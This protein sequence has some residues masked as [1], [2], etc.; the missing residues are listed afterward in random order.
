MSYGD[1]GL[2][3]TSIGGM[4]NAVS[5]VLGGYNT[6]SYYRA[7]ADRYLY[8]KGLNELSTYNQIDYDSTSTAYRIRSA[9]S[10]GEQLFGKQ[11]TTLARLGDSTGNT[12]RAIVRNSAKNQAE[13]VA[14]LD[15]QNALSGFER[16]RQTMLEGIALE[17]ES[18]MAKV[19]GK[20][21][22]IA[23]WINGGASLLSTIGTVAG[24]W[25]S[26]PYGSNRLNDNGIYRISGGR[27][28]NSNAGLVNGRIIGV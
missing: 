27:T 10:K 1:I 3:T 28:Y 24:A 6:N 18:K 16:R 23:G 5:N 2:Y 4:L 7:V 11:R 17:A 14:M 13:D 20:N 15:Y 9:M 25:Y 22:V 26:G 12:A 8:Q 21:A 19:A